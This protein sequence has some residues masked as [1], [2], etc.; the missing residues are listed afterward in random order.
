M[1]TRRIAGDTKDI[2]YE[3]M[4]LG[5]AA[6]KLAKDPEAF[7]L[8]VMPHNCGDTISS[9]A[10]STVGGEGMVPGVHIGDKYSIFQ[11]GGSNP[12][13]DNANER[14]SNP[15][16]IILSASMMLR[17]AN[18]P[19]FADLLEDAVFNTH[20]NLEFKSPELGGNYST[21]EFTQEVIKNIS[22]KPSTMKQLK[23]DSVSLEM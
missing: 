5:E 20:K 2:K 22:A 3:E 7:D 23:N 19:S 9:I 21:R 18:L 10:F 4:Y 8:I 14:N 13:Y 1:N 16:G 12:D 15:T 11:Q 6:A 17:Q